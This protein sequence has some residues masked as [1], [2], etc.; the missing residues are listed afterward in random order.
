MFQTI[1]SLLSGSVY[2][3]LP[4]VTPGHASV[5]LMYLV[6]S[7]RRLVSAL[8]QHRLGRRYYVLFLIDNY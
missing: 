3:C 1:V 8:V 7:A 4:G 2:R 5:D 6:R